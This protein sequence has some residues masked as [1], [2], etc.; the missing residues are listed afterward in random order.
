[1]YYGDETAARKEIQINKITGE[2]NPAD[3]ATKHFAIAKVE[4]LQVKMH[5]NYGD[6]IADKAAKLHSSESKV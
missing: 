3:L 6:G 4:K 2:E 5:M 1:M